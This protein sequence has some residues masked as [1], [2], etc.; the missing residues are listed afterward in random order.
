[1][2]KIESMELYTQGVEVWNSWA[3]E[4]LA[5]RTKLIETGEWMAEIDPL[6]KLWGSN[7]AT[8]KWLDAVMSNFSG[9]VFKNE[10][11][12]I[13]FVFP[14][15]AKFTGTVFTREVRFNGTTFNG[16]TDF[17]TA[18]FRSYA[19]FGE[20]KFLGLTSFYKAKFGF[21]GNFNGAEFSGGA[22]FSSATFG[23]AVFI[24]ARFDS[25]AEFSKAMVNTGYFSQAVFNGEARFSKASFN[26]DAQFMGVKFNR[27]LH[28]DEANFNSNVMF[29]G[30]MMADRAS[31]DRAEFKGRTWFDQSLFKGNV[32]FDQAIFANLTSFFRVTFQKESSFV[33]IEGRSLFTLEESVFFLVPDFAQA[34]FAEALRL[35]NSHFSAAPR[36][37]RRLWKRELRSTNTDLASRWRTLKRLALQGHDHERE[38]NFFAEEIKSLR[39]VKDWLLPNPLSF[40]KG[41]PVCWPGGGRYWA[42]LLYEWFSDFGRSALRPLLWWVTIT[43]IFATYYF[44][45]YS[46]LPSESPRTTP[47][48]TCTGDPVAAALYL[49]IHNGLVISGLGRAEKLAQSYACLYGREENSGFFPVMP[50]AVVFAGLIQ[51]ILSA[52]LI[53]LFLLALRNYFRIK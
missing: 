29:H 37:S 20:T 42:G 45:H 10:M 16:F 32:V 43:S 51:T 36:E 35:D 13:N 23:T 33:A 30:A 38:L 47:A 12:F 24:G 8:E 15:D 26:G 5:E 48:F 18:V 49:S 25:Y 28:F 41:S 46:D 50:D 31:F 6:G 21:S 2:N 40:R 22:E 3:A 27:S 4:M 1:M 53:F 39:G 7:L 17:E 11:N 52:I 34:H 19:G 44:L 14:G 9:E